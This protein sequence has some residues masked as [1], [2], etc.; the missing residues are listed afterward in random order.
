M[1]AY[2]FQTE[3]IDKNVF[4]RYVTH[5]EN[6][7]Q[8]LEVLFL[9]NRPLFLNINFDE[10]DA[11]LSFESTLHLSCL[12]QNE[13]DRLRAE[14][15]TRDAALAQKEV[16]IYVFSSSSDHGRNSFVNI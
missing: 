15:Q 12:L 8:I 6:L 11:S 9:K 14:I 10:E 7:Y 2:F 3:S 13:V 5:G 1:C 4:S 16:S